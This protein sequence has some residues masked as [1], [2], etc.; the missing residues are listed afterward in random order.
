MYESL[1]SSNE[2]RLLVLESDAIKRLD[3]SL[4][5]ERYCGAE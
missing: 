2:I 5:H 4:L 1:D 3:A